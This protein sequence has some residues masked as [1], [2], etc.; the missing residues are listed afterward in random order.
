MDQNDSIHPFFT[1]FF[2]SITAFE[3]LYGLNKIRIDATYRLYL[4][5]IRNIG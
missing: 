5:P 1:K 2:G 3:H 4:F